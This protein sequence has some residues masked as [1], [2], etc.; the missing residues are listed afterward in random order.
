MMDKRPPKNRT[1]AEGKM[2]KK[3][4]FSKGLLMKIQDH[5]SQ[6]NRIIYRMSNNWKKIGLK[7]KDLLYYINRYIK[8]H[9]NKETLEDILPSGSQPGKLYGMCKVQSRQS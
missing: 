9:I 7:K 6:W 8:G 2:N 5:I 1:I 4:R 3:M